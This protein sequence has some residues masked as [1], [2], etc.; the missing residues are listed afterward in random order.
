MVLTKAT[1]TAPDTP[2]RFFTPCVCMPITG[3]EAHNALVEMPRILPLEHPVEASRDDGSEARRMSHSTTVSTA[4]VIVGTRSKAPFFSSTYSIFRLDIQR[5]KTLSFK[6][7]G[8]LL[9]R[10]SRTSKPQGTHDRRHPF[11]MKRTDQKPH[12]VLFAWPKFQTRCLRAL[13]KQTRDSVVD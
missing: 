7:G 2:L 13:L 9:R 8:G 5:G 3:N 10:S 11:I 12:T 1:W 6:I 4:N